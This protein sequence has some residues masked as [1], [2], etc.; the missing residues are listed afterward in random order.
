MPDWSCGHIPSDVIY[1]QTVPYCLC[2]HI[3]S[4]V[5]YKRIVSYWSCWHIL[6]DV[7]Y[8]RIVSYRSCWHISC[9]CDLQ[10]VRA[11]FLR[12]DSSAIPIFFAHFSQNTIFKRLMLYQ[13]CTHIY[14]GLYHTYPVHTFLSDHESQTVCATSNLFSK[15]CQ[16]IYKRFVLYRSSSY[17][18]L[19]TRITNGLCHTGPVW[20][21]LF[22]NMFL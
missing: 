7:I 2:W 22:P 5:I 19:R 11:I 1:K 20:S 13:S 10:T 21:I 17:N 18:F 15:F 16:N 6:S 8:K 4:Y 14:H 9:W 3:L 12:Y